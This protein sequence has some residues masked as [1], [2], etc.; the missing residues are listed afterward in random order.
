MTEDERHRNWPISSNLFGTEQILPAAQMRLLDG[1][2][3][4]S[5]NTPPWQDKK[6]RLHQL[7]GERQ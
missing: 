1:A 7:R 6:V 5:R 4:V 2:P 3:L